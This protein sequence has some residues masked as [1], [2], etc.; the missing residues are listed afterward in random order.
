MNKTFKSWPC[1]KNFARQ[2]LFKLYISSCRKK[3]V[4]K[5]KIMSEVSLNTIS[6]VQIH[7]EEIATDEK[8]DN[9]S[10][11]FTVGQY[12]IKVCCFE[13]W[14][15]TKLSQKCREYCYWKN[16]STPHSKYY[17]QCKLIHLIKEPLLL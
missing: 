5:T 6:F 8:V 13:R 16:Y 11:V 4:M 15:T 14:S 2:D 3:K 9:Y 7:N 1:G 10:H 12:D 17:L